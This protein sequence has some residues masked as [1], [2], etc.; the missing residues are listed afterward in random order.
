MRYLE[1]QKEYERLKELFANCEE[2]QLTLVDGTIWEAAR[3]RVELNNLNKIVAKT[4]LVKVNPNNPAM[5]KELPV[6]KMIVKVRANYLNYISKLS[7]IL[8]KSIIEEED[9]LS[10]YE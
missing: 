8:G 9:E 5:Q 10:D 1:V 3:L 2:N 6:S 4:G 7:N